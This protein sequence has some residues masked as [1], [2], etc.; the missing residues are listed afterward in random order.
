M[1]S[2]E[3]LDA[4]LR[5]AANGWA[6]F[7]CHHPT[8][9]GCSCGRADCTSPAKHPATRRGLHDASSD[10]VQI[11]RWW[12]ERPDANVAIRTGRVSRLVV[13]D[14]DLPHGPTSLRR[15]LGP[16]TPT[17]STGSGGAHLYF[18]PHGLQVT[19]SA[20]RLGPGLDVRGDGGYVIAP[21]S[22]HASGTAYRWN[23]LSLPVPALPA[24]LARTLTR[25]PEPR[26]LPSHRGGMRAWAEAVLDEQVRAVRTAAEGT[27]ND[28]LNRAAFRLGRLAARGDVDPQ[29]ARSELER[30]ARA[31]G[32]GQREAARTTDSGLTAGLRVGADRSWSR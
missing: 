14:V 20:G 8:P 6:V 7:P 31:A 5:Y 18:D 11:E 22:R 17:V 30:A 19:N 23:Q 25:T 13:I 3:R 4:A 28:T 29:R 2:N 26:A 21:P 15:L 9:A 16:A 32:L 12:R 1:V 27:R 10:P 24:R